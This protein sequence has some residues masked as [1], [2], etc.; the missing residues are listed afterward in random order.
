MRIYRISHFADLSGEGGRRAS[1]RWH[2]KGRPVVYC[3]G[4]A[5]AAMLEAITYIARDDPGLLPSTFQLL[6]IELPDEVKREVVSLTRLSA[7]WKRNLAHTRS[8]G[9]QWLRRQATAVLVVPSALAPDTNN[10]LLNPA[11]P[12][13]Q[14]PRRGRIHI[15]R[16]ERYP[17]DSRLFQIGPKARR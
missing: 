6:E 8:L 2:H 10:F 1:A 17:F 12:E 3:A 4:N 9:E 7:D 5:A 16:A 13:L 15:V 11:H 14:P